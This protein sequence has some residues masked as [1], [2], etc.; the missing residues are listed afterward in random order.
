[1]SRQ[2]LQLDDDI[3][4]IFSEYSVIPPNFGSTSKHQ[5]SNAHSVQHFSS[6]FIYILTYNV[7]YRDNNNKTKER[8][9]RE[10]LLVR[11][12]EEEQALKTGLPSKPNPTSNSSKPNDPEQSEMQS[13]SD[14][15]NDSVDIEESIHT[16]QPTL[17][18]SVDTERSI[19][20]QKENPIDSVDINTQQHNLTDSTDIE[21]PIEDSSQVT[22]NNI[23]KEIPITTENTLNIGSSE[24]QQKLVPTSD[25]NSSLNE[26]VKTVVDPPK[27]IDKTDTKEKRELLIRRDSLRVFFANKKH[28]PSNQSDIIDNLELDID[29]QIQSIE[30]S[31]NSDKIPEECETIDS[32]DSNDLNNVTSSSSRSTQESIEL[33]PDEKRQRAAANRSMQRKELKNLKRQKKL[34]QNDDQDIVIMAPVKNSTEDVSNDTP[35]VVVDSVV[36]EEKKIEKIRKR[37]SK[38]SE[39]DPNFSDGSIDLD[40]LIAENSDLDSTKMPLEDDGDDS[41]DD[42]FWKI[43]PAELER[44]LTPS[45]TPLRR[46]SP[47]PQSLPDTNRISPHRTFGVIAEEDE[48]FSDTLLEVDGQ[49]VDDILSSKIDGLNI[50]DVEENMGMMLD[51]PMLKESSPSPIPSPFSSQSDGKPGTPVG[52]FKTGYGS[53]FSPSPLSPTSSRASS[54]GDPDEYETMSNG[55]FT[56]VRSAS[57]TKS[58]ASG[59]RRPSTTSGLRTPS[60]AGSHTPSRMVTPTRVEQNSNSSTATPFRS[61]STS[62]VSNSSTEESTTSSRGTT[63]PSR[64]AS[65]TYRMSMYNVAQTISENNNHPRP[66]SR[67]SNGSADEVLSRS[68]SNNGSSPGARSLSRAGS[69]ATPKSPSIASSTQSRIRNSMPPGSINSKK[70]GTPARSLSQLQQPSTGLVRPSSRAGLAKSPVPPTPTSP[71]NSR[72][73]SRLGAAQKGS[74]MKK[75]RPNSIAVGNKYNKYSNDQSLYDTAD[76]KM[77]DSS[78]IRSPPGVRSINQYLGSR[79]SSDSLSSHDDYLIFTPP[80]SPTGASET[81][82]LTSLA[83]SVSYGSSPGRGTSP[84]PSHNIPMTSP[85]RIASKPKRTSMISPS[86]PSPSSGGSKLPTTKV[87]SPS[88]FA[89]PGNR[90]SIH[91]PTG[92][93]PP[94]QIG[95]RKTK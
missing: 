10:L 16:Q 37:R 9:M 86:T 58:G 43:D 69:I 85:S 2:Q 51:I 76:T 38:T 56:S 95:F 40:I 23:L 11:K 55:S 57:S 28:Q 8:R 79:H 5:F 18:D 24:E 83:S 31:N 74:P 67:I 20:I 26:D 59:I 13:Q 93:R 92:L 42:D 3:F 35:T 71:P 27:S 81:D 21:K 29:T 78:G 91:Q 88:K 84:V 17:A 65:P 7:N 80:E 53:H 73:L 30:S 54:I 33:N 15:T 87:T 64:I 89:S 90:Q 48:N 19:N 22:D 77:I 94:S 41:D 52:T 47:D 61:R 6:Y 45:T 82:S 25:E 14:Q 32:N 4:D 63:S 36:S 1:M 44:H 50:E 72:S 75:N 68:T 70:V 49:E 34:Q 62:V 39:S 60:R 12:L 66:P 46:L